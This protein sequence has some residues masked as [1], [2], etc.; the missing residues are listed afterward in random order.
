MAKLKRDSWKLIEIIIMRYPDR[1]QEYE[2]YI[3]DIMS[4]SSGTK[5]GY[6]GEG[7]DYSPPQSVTEAK[8]MKMNSAYADRLKREIEAVE[9]AYNNLS[10]EGQKV[11]R[12]RYWSQRDHKVPYLQITQCNYSERQ[13][14]RI[15]YK[16]I[17]MVGRYLGEFT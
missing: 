1:K 7:A 10:E 12:V 5:E 3:S 14:K 9:Y 13:M 6:L 11:M 16:I 17:C 2:E 8:A 4:A 15:V